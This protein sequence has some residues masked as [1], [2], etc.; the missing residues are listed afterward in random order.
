MGV[1]TAPKKGGISKEGAI[2]FSAIG[3]LAIALAAW[4][5]GTYNRY[6][7]NIE[8]SPR[9]QTVLDTDLLNINV[10]PDEQTMSVILK[11]E[12]SIANLA[13]ICSSAPAQVRMDD[14]MESVK[15]LGS[16][17]PFSRRD[18]AIQVPIHEG[19]II[20]GGFMGSELSMHEFTQMMTQAEVGDRYKPSEFMDDLKTAGIV[21]GSAIALTIGGIGMRK[22][23]KA[24]QAKLAAKVAA[25]EAAKAAK[26]SS[27][28]PEESRQAQ[29]LKRGG[30]E[31]DPVKWSGRKVTPEEAAAYVRN[32]IYNE[33]DLAEAKEKEDRE[34]G[35]IDTIFIVGLKRL[36][37]QER[38]KREIVVEE[39]VHTANVLK[40]RKRITVEELD[41]D[42]DKEL[43]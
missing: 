29:A 22:L 42:M 8:T 37:L 30:G 43:P 16:D 25:K 21:T 41:P 12:N 7:P 35:L 31:L 11:G 17:N 2:V 24:K 40:D 19:N 6:F 36:L 38:V 5:Y 15:P 10:N 18:L 33:R 23:S 9:N 14:C 26:K 27:T 32:N 20:L 39:L 3:T 4:G 28:P 34:K 1:E 13:A